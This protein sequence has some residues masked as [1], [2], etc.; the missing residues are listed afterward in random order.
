MGIVR[1]KAR[2]KKN[3][4]IELSKPVENKYCNYSSYCIVITPLTIMIYLSSWIYYDLY[5]I[6]NTTGKVKYFD[7]VMKEIANKYVRFDALT[8]IESI[9]T[10]SKDTAE[11]SLRVFLKTYFR[12]SKALQKCINYYRSKC[13]VSNT[14]TAEMIFN[15]MIDYMTDALINNEMRVYEEH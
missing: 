10:Q 12:Y 6:K 9:Q 13:G 5:L 7:S 1:L 3:E 11:E 15:D 4:E 8:I 14:K 2:I